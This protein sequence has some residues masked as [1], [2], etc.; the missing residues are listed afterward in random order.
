MQDSQA[1]PLTKILSQPI[2]GYAL[3][4]SGSGRK[5]ERF[6][7]VI[8]DRPSSLASW[9]QR[10]PQN[11]IWNRA[12]ARYS[13]P[14]SWAHK[15]RA[16]NSFKA[17]IAGASIELELM[18]NG[19]VGLFP[20]HAL[21]LPLLASSINYLANQNPAPKEIRVLNLFAYT[22]L[23][24][25][26]ALKSH[27]LVHV[28]HVD[29]AKRAIERAKHNVALNNIDMN[30]RVRWIVDDALSFMAREGRKGNKYDLIVI[31]PPSFSRVSKQNSWTL[32]EKVAE[33]ISLVMGVLNRI[34]GAKIFFTNHSSA[35]TS[36]IARNVALD[37]F[38]DRAVDVE[39]ASLS[40]A[41]LDSPRRLPAGSLI[42]LS[43]M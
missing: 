39:I 37:T 14:D 9:R 2:P 18:S 33:I 7:D 40:L 22:G 27:P 43:L 16:F 3:L 25:A 21:Y 31:D 30:S 13:P 20:E 1:D 15:G 11:P 32:D 19:Q 36:E 5:L 6:G 24:T 28:T 34:P 35:S 10:Q 38:G 4:D 17:D 26:F 41:E 12:A 29:L 42:V 23:A 8:L